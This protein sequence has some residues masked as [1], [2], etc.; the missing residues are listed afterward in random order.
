MPRQLPR[1]EREQVIRLWLDC[2]GLAT[3]RGRR[4]TRE[5]FLGHLDR[6]GALQLDSVNVLARAHLV[7]LWSR[8]GQF[9]PETVDRWVYR[10]RLAYEFW[11]HEASLLPLRSL[12]HS[13]RFM[14]DWDPTSKYWARLED[15]KGMKRR[16]LKRIRDEGGLESAHFDSPGRSGNWWG[17]KDAKFA[18]EMLWREGR[19]AVSERRHFRRVYD[20]AERVYPEGP[21]AT[22]KA[23]EE[24]W[25]LDGLRGNGVATVRHL[26]HYMSTP[27]L[28][29]TVGNVVLERLRKR[30]RVVQVEVPGFD[31]PAYALPEDLERI[32]RLATP[33]G[34][35]LLCPFDSML[36]QKRRAEELMDFRYRIEIYT[37]EPK[38]VYG[39][40]VLPILHEGRLV[41]RLDPRLDR[42]AKRLTIHAIHLEPGVKRTPE[43]DAG[44]GDALRD[45]AAFVGAE[46]LALPRGWGK[47]AG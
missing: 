27:W 3:P 14:R 46:H 12:P 37:P 28:G 18:L 39:Y 13:R 26:Q 19:L 7:T 20:L 32:P 23:Y 6:C 24:R 10:D 21:T 5:Q 29:V 4:L 8:Y 42:A 47:L 40:Y 1:I 17:W 36:W 25:V 9:K 34:T 11:G 44:L 2:Q 15:P 30:R 31:E 45:L 35:T 38:R 16:V 22:R 43:L 41:G 33:R